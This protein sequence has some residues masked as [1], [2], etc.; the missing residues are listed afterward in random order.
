M[1]LPLPQSQL[2]AIT[3]ACQ[4]APRGAPACL[5]VGAAARHRPGESDIEASRQVIYAA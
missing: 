1:S 3:A 2:D 5:R 4:R